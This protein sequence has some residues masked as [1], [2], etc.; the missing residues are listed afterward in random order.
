[1]NNSRDNPGPKTKIFEILV[2]YI[3]LR[4]MVDI[5]IYDLIEVKV[6]RDIINP[7]KGRTVLEG[8]S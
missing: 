3:H 4:F 1:M 8:S 6:F 5:I 7:K 2:F